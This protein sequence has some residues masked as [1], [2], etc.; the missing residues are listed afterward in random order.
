MRGPGG[1]ELPTA[2]SVPGAEILVSEYFLL[3]NPGL[4]ERRADSEEGAGKTHSV[5]GTLLCHKV[6]KGLKEL[7]THNKL[8]L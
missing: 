3:G 7:T 4:L 1:S 5:S 2:V 8:R 6:K